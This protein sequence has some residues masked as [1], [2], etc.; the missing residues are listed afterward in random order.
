M[1][2]TT[3]W[4]CRPSTSATDS[5]NPVMYMAPATHCKVGGG[6]HK[7]VVDLFL[8]ASKTKETSESNK[9]KSKFT[10]HLS[11]HIQETHSAPYPATKDGGDHGV[12][13]SAPNTAV[14][15]HPNP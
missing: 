12:D 7:N 8:M 14:L 9:D 5:E 3:H 10:T 1:P 2:R 4:P 15:A 6:G 13:S 11:K